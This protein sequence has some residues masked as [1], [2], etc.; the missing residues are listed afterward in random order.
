MNP[1]RSFAIT[2][3][4]EA[5]IP[6]LLAMIHE[7]AAFENLEQELEVTQAS[8]FVALFGE[9]PA[10]NAFLAHA[11]TEPAGYAVYYR[12]FSTFS[13]R[14]GIFLDDVYV[15]PA[16]RNHGLGRALLERVARAG[17]GVSPGRYEWIALR[18]NENALRFYQNLGA[19]LLTE[20]IFVRMSGELLHRFI[21]A[22]L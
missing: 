17:I 16:Y 4:V 22:A 1:M 9:R 21:E 14:P 6:D 5:D 20:W 3:A 11:E 19:Q 2:E 10:A 15:R 8:L 13:G 12:T 18:W 7:L